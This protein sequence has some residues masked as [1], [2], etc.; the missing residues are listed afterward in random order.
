MIFL[1]KSGLSLI[2]LRRAS[3]GLCL[4]NLKVFIAIV[5]NP[6]NSTLVIRTKRADMCGPEPT[7]IHIRIM[8]STKL[9]LMKI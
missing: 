9:T 2:N 1:R 5:G 3:S 8:T 4:L 6:P 7:S